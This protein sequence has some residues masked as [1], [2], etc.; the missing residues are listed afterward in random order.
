MKYFVVLA[1]FL[2]FGACS[3]GGTSKKVTDIQQ[4]TGQQGNTPVTPET[5]SVPAEVP[6]VAKLPVVGFG[7]E[8][9]TYDG[10][11]EIHLELTL[12]EASE[13]PVTVEVELIDGSATFP[14]DY[15][16]FMG[17]P[18]DRKLTVVFEPNQTRIDLPEIFIHNSA[19]CDSDL[20]AKV[21]LGE[22]SAATIEKDTT[23]IILTCN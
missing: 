20:T 1:G 10:E 4:P 6:P 17:A 9:Y 7:F 11:L 19:E 3:N 21:T 16:G 23:R 2:I 13:K 15:A 8:E 14:R 12:S 18:Y 5:P 22:A